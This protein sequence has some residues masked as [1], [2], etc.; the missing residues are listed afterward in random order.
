MV[1]SRRATPSKATADHAAP[2]S[3][4]TRILKLSLIHI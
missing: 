4:G 2:D 1:Q 3:G